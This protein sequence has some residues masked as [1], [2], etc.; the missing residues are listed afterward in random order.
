MKSLLL[1]TACIAAIALSSKSASAQL[2]PEMVNVV[3]DT[4]RMGTDP[5]QNNGE[6]H[7]P[8]KVI[9]GTFRIAKTEITVKQWKH[10]CEATANPMPTEV[11]VYGWVDE[12]PMVNISW[13][14][15]V[16]YC[17]WLSREKRQKYRLPTEAEWEF[18]ARGGSGTKGYPFSG[19]KGA[20]MV[21]W[22]SE[23][24][25]GKPHAVATKR[26]NELGLYDMSGNVY[27]WCADR[28]GNYSG[29]VAMNPKGAA[30]G[31]LRVYRGGSWYS[32]GS[33]CGVSVRESNNPKDHFGFVGFRPVEE[34]DADA[35][36]STFA[37]QPTSR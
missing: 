15:A 7:T 16:E 21:G 2:Y 22:T 30:T 4:F 3:G 28:Y 26:A 27:E 13:E 32:Q 12:N 23:N 11:P 6:D 9:L 14:D 17:E 19:G 5:S 29:K 36:Q 37:A 10:Y 8:H 33:Y 34:F 18:A 25:G 1:K 24:S 20:D 31:S 35:P